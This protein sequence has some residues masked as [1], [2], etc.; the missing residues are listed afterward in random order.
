MHGLSKN[1]NAERGLPGR[2]HYHT[3]Q[4]VPRQRR[5]MDI[6]SLT[7]G[8]NNSLFSLRIT[9]NGMQCECIKAIFPQSPPTLHELQ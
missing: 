6:V 7:H 4:L 8:I 9:Y 2:S 5:L 1:C 3:L